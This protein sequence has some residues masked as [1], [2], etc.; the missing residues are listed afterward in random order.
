M[1]G[2]TGLADFPFFLF[3][4]LW[5]ISCPFRSVTS[6]WLVVLITVLY[7]MHAFA[8]AGRYDGTV[9][10]PS[11]HHACILHTASKVI[12]IIIIYKSTCYVY[13]LYVCMYVQISIS[14]W[15]RDGVRVTLR[16]RSGNFCC[17]GTW[18]DG[19]GAHQVRDQ[20]SWPGR[21]GSRRLK[22]SIQLLV[23]SMENEIYH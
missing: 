12:I 10:L 8:P 17:R 14:T 2:G 11:I 1:P 22:N 21:V 13:I 16:T 19:H 20:N 4:F 7:H 3:L 6:F 9:R 5:F 15:S 23:Y 18:D